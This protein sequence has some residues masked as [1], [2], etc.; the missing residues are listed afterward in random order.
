VGEGRGFCGGADVRQFNTPAASA[1]PGLR[2]VLSRLVRLPVPVVAAIHGFALGG[3]L[4]LALG[5]HYRLVD[6]DA[7]IGLTEV[8]LGLIPGG[9]GTQRLPRLI[10]AGPALEV[11]PY[12]AR[13]N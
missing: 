1:E 4:E 13:T 6:K 10:G 11:V 12:C 8:T 3:G 9:G 5:A 7:T 2:D